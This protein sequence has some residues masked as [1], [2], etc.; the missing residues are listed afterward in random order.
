MAKTY[1]EILDEMCKRVKECST[2]EG[3]FIYTALAPFAMELALLYLQLEQD[4]KNGFADTADY[5]HLKKLALDRGLIPNQATHA[6][7]IGKFDVEIPVGS[8]FSINT[9]SFISGEQI[10]GRQDGYFY[11]KLTSEQTGKELNT[12]F[13]KLTPITFIRNLNYAYLIEITVPAEDDEDIESFRER[14]FETFNKK[15]F[16][17][18]KSDYIDK[19]NSFNGVGACKVYPLWEGGGTVKIVII[20][21][22]IMILYILESVILMEL[23]L[24]FYGVVNGKNIIIL[25]ELD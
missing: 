13:G 15:S 7:G 21:R 4:E 17:G 6:V 25:M 10:T 1:E 12:V 22:K 18:N 20:K 9:Y 2:M 19:I 23:I 5:E 16:G 3:S 24:K 8:K 11:Y 14:Y